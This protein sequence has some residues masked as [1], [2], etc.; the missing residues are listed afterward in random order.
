MGLGNV[1]GLSS[2]QQELQRVAQRVHAHVDLGAETA[3]APAQGLGFL[4]PLPGGAPAA[5]GWARTTVLSM[6]RCSK[7]GSPAKR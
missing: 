3:S 6:I 2:G 7:S 5:Q 1:M 4:P